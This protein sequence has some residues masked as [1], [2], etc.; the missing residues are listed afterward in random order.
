[1][2]E[3]EQQKSNL[4][5]LAAA[6]GLDLSDEHIDDLVDQ[7]ETTARRAEKLTEIDVEGLGPASVFVPEEGRT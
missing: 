2:P 4:R 1:M 3:S 7:F 5:T 6:V